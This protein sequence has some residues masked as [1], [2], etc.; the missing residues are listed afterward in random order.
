MGTSLF[1]D[2]PYYFIDNTTNACNVHIYGAAK[3]LS[4]VN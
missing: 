4:D 1:V 3:Y 2:K